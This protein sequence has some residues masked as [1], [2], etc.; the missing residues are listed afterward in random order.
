[1]LIKYKA[2]NSMTVIMLIVIKHFFY[3]DINCDI[4][5]LGEIYFNSNFC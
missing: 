3:C 1:M 4:M 2:A 5:P